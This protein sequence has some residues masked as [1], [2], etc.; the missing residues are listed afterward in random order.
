MLWR[1]VCSM[2]LICNVIQAQGLG[3]LLSQCWG[4]E[5]ARTGQHSPVHLTRV[6]E[7]ESPTPRSRRGGYSC[8]C[9]C[10]LFL[11]RVGWVY[12]LVLGFVLNAD[13]FL[14]DKCIQCRFRSVL[15]RRGHSAPHCCVH[16]SCRSIVMMISSSYRRMPLRTSSTSLTHVVVRF[17][18]GPGVLVR[19]FSFTFS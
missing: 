14:F 8:I 5:G 16:P 12:P 11:L 19:V 18:M 1:A 4:C 6:C 9:V 10:C 13:R 17:S 3:N 2:K 15:L 7:K